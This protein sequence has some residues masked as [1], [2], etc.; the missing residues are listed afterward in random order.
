MARHPR[1][2]VP[3][4]ALHVHHRGNNRQDC[5]YQDNDRL[6][7]LS[8]LRDLSRLRGCALHAY[9]L[10][11]NHI[12]VL[13][14][15][16]DE[17]GCSLMMR[18]LAR[19]YSSYFNGRYSRTGQLWEGRFRSCL[20]D[21]ARYVLGCYR[22]IELN[23]VRAHMVSSPGD[24]PWSSYAGNVGARDDALLTPH[25]EY[26]T[27][28]RSAY[29]QLVGSDDAQTV[30]AI[31]EATEAGFPLVGNELKAQLESKGARLD[32]DRPGPRPEAPHDGASEQLDLLTE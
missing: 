5:F 31:R 24:Y 19:R 12:H 22:Y 17:T 1:L 4:V 27:V 11:T 14:T 8:I 2:I 29:Q 23:P 3:G 28:T 16:M 25:A 15:P 7:Y 13:L 26:L 6:V 10:M 21:S 18:D 20:V 30:K 9:C 32:R